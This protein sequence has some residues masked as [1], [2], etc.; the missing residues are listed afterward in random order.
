MSVIPIA[1][2]LSASRRAGD[3]GDALDLRGAVFGDGLVLSIEPS[4][5]LVLYEVSDAG[6]AH[7]I[8]TFDDPAAAWRAVDAIDTAPERAVAA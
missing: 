4:G 2:A 8:G 1:H 7:R 3:P 6:R 5:R